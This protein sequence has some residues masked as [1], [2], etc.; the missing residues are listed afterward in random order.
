MSL[1]WTEYNNAYVA[2]RDIYDKYD[3]DSIRK[4]HLEEGFDVLFAVTPNNT[5]HPAVPVA[6]VFDKQTF[7]LDEAV[8][9]M[10]MIR[11]QMV[12]THQSMNKKFPPIITAMES[13]DKQ[14]MILVFD[15]SD[16][17]AERKTL[18]KQLDEFDR[19]Q[20]A[21]NN[22]P[23]ALH[24]HISMFECNDAYVYVTD[25]EFNDPIDPSQFDEYDLVALPIGDGMMAVIQDIDGDDPHIF[26]FVFDRDRFTQEEAVEIVLGGTVA[27]GM[28]DGRVLQ[29]PIADIIPKEMLS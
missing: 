26:E 19:Q 8:G 28:N 1:Q 29:L 25:P 14:T 16:P 18:K 27:L 17:T 10:R 2:Q 4:V 23:Q 12:Y 21:E 20:S 5:R 7:T 11:V 6:F 15:N 9:I 3:R 22:A 13:P 24:V